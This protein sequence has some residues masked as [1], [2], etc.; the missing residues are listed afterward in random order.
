MGAKVKQ[1]RRVVQVVPRLPGSVW[2]ALGPIPVR[3]VDGLKDDKGC[4]LYGYW[5]PTNREI[6]IREGIHPTT[7]IVTAVHEWLHS[8][9]YDAGVKLPTKVE[10]SV[11][12]CLSTAI[13]ADLLSHR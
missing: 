1:R 12:D 9:L 6:L 11:C 4:D 2:S 5:D 3:L 8:A 7:A 13:V 10:E